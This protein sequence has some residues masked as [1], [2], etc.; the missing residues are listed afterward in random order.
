MK[1]GIIG[2]MDSEI[3]RFLEDL[4]EKQV[5][6]IHGF[7]YYEGVMAGREVV[8]T[9]S[10]VGKVN[11]AICATTLMSQFQVKSV[12]FTGVA[13]AV[14]PDLEIGDIVV[15]SECQYHDVDVTALGFARGQ[16]PFQE[17]SI[18]PAD[19]FLVQWAKE[20]GQEMDGV[21]VK[22]GKVL[23]GDQFISSSEAVHILREELQGACVE[24]EGAAVA[25]VCFMLNTPFVVI[26]SMSDRAD[27]S[28]HVNFE[29][30][31]LLAADRSYMMVRYLLHKIA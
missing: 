6:Q 2:A 5:H 23:S 30:F 9:K 24:M 19:P 26:R 11:A 4:T 18:F 17:T 1:I 29:E 10:G 27:H 25:H 14:H 15:S 20:A 31:T 16:I 8:I 21:Q 13:G 7:S 12:L 22:V 28:A 3:A